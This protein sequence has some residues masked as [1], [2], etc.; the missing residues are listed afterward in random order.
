MNKKKV[1]RQNKRKGKNKKST[2]R[3]KGKE[4]IQWGKNAVKGK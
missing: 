1:K 3:I 2:Q 4:S